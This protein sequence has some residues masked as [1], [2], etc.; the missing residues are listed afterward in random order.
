[1]KRGVWIVTLTFGRLEIRSTESALTEQGAIEAAQRYA[2]ALG[3][4]GQPTRI[5]SV[6]IG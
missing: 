6:R 5:T 2:R 4:S 1:M 3:Y